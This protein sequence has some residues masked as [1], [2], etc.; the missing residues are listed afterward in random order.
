[1]DKD[2]WTVEQRGE[3]VRF[4]HIVSDRL[5]GDVEVEAFDELVVDVVSRVRRRKAATAVIRKVSDEVREAFGAYGIGIAT[6]GTVGYTPWKGL[7]KSSF[8]SYQEAKDEADYINR[9]VFK[10]TDK[11]A[12]L[13]VAGTM[14]NGVSREPAIEQE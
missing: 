9:E 7:R 1:M 14:R 2:I 12:Y 10:L 13:I 5:I 6:E 8:H 4:R 3:T 11:E